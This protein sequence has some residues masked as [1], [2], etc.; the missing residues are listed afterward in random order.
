MGRQKKQP[1][2]WKKWQCPCK[3]NRWFLEDGNFRRKTLFPNIILALF[4]TSSKRKKRF[5]VEGIVRGRPTI[6]NGI[7]AVLKVPLN[8]ERLFLVDG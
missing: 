3:I 1:A 7:V 2:G 5:Q 4:S 6:P 8:R